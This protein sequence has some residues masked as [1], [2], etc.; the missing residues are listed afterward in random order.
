[1][2]DVQQVDGG[3]APSSRLVVILSVAVLLLLASLDQTIVATALP[4]IVADLGGVDHLSWVVTA[5][6]LSSTVVAPIYGKLGDLYGRKIVVSAA[7]FL[8]LLGS[9]L[10]GLANSMAFLIAARTLQGLGGGGLFVLAFSIVGDVIPPRERGKIQ[11][12]FGGVFSLSSVAGPLIGGYFV[13]HL[14]WHWIFYVNLPLGILAMVGFGLAFKTPTK[15]VS[16]D[17]DYLGAIMLAMALGATVLFSSLG[18]RTLGWASWPI[19]LMIGLAVIGLVGFILAE[20]GAREPIL[21]LALFRINT[22]SMASLIGFVVGVSMFGAITFLPLYLQLVKGVSPSV[23]GLQLVP[24]MLGILTSSITSG[25]IMSRTGRYKFLPILGAALMVVGLVLLSSVGAKTDTLTLS[26][27]MVILGIG[28]GPMMGTLTTVVQNAVPRQ[29][30]GS[31]TAGGVLFR[32]VGGSIGVAVF[33]SIFGAFLAGSLPKAVADKIDVASLNAAALA[34]MPP[35]LRDPVFNGI[36]SA[37]HP[38][39]LLAAI[40]AAFAFLL[41]LFL[42]EVPLNSKSHAEMAAEERARNQDAGEPGDEASATAL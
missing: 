20:R 38:I 33:G 17:I 31:A 12:A 2:S 30:L 22:F 23:S 36:V 28:L 29:H 8:F 14:S 19:L 42:E 27:Y 11:G 4:T 25:Q 41:S 16:H 18:G 39:F 35:E 21:P 3:G 37:L 10:A 34:K 9:A 15:R 6:L 26:L 40:V 5:Y 7:I 13:E 1:M 24:M 32:Q